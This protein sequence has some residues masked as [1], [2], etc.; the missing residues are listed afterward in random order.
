VKCIVGLG[1]PGREYAETRH[2]VGFRVI[3]LL[4]NTLKISLKPGNGEFLL[5]K[6]TFNDSEILLVAPLTYMNESGIAVRD[7]CEKFG[8]HLND[9]LVVYDDFQLPLGQLRFRENGSDGGHNGMASII[10]HLNTDD[11]QRLRIG[12]GGASLP[13]EDRKNQMADYVLA[14]FEK[15][16]EPIISAALDRAADAVQEWINNGIVHAM[17][18][19]NTTLNN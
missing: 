17:N 2:N 14:P 6:R 3:A 18:K 15:D 7:V 10:Y 9:L 13:N 16:E 5:G 1:N 19:F 8:V 11:I 12:I 4:T